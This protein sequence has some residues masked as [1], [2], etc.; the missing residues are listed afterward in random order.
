VGRECWNGDIGIV[1]HAGECNDAGYN[2]AHGRPDQP[3]WHHSNPADQD[4][5]S[6]MAKTVTDAAILLGVMESASP[7]PNGSATNR[8]MPPQNHDYT[9][10]L[11]P[12][13]LKAH[14][15]IPHVLSYRRIPRF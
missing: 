11:K 6:P 4:T 1:A 3:L 2:Q 7:D 10:F 12:E 14:I 15:G 13:G 5:A 9:K 8:C